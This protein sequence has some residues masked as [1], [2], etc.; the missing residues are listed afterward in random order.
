MEEKME[1]IDPV[2][3]SAGLT[4]V[5]HKVRIVLSLHRIRRDLE[6]A[7]DYGFDPGQLYTECIEEIFGRHPPRHVFPPYTDVD[8]NR[9]I[10][11]S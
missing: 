11:E 2:H 9:L 8:P 4:N 1:L 3:R 7:R 6:L 10:G 5:P